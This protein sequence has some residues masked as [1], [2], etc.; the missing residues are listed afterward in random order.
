MQFRLHL[1]RSLKAAEWYIFPPE[2]TAYK[3]LTFNSDGIVLRG[4][5]ADRTKLYLGYSGDA[6]FICTCGRGTWQRRDTV[7]G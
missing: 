2:S 1:I 3:Q 6:I 5:G 4:A 7:P